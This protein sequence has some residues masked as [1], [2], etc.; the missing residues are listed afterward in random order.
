MSA[1]PRR[2]VLVCGVVPA[3]IVALL[4][5]Y[6]PAFLERLEYASY[7]AL[8]RAARTHP[9]GGDVVIVDVDERSLS[10]VGQWPWRRNLV[11]N[12]VSRIRDLSASAIALDIVFAESDRYAGSGAATD[13]AMAD[14]LRPGKVVLGYALTFDNTSKPS[15]A[16]M[17]HPLGLVLVRRGDERAPDPF[18][19]ATGVVCS[20]PVLT[21]AAGASGFFNAAPDPDGLLR[22]VPL[23]AAFDG[24]VYPSL[25]LAAVIAA[26]NIHDVSLRVGNVNSATLWFGSQSVPLDGKSNMRLRYRGPRRTF[27]YV[28][29]TDVLSG[30]VTADA[31]KDKIVFVGTTALGTREVVSTPIDT[32]F[33]GVEVQAT[34]ADNLLQQDYIR[35]PE[36]GSAIETLGVLIVGIIVSLLV[37]R[38]GLAWGGA[39]IAAYL[40][41]IW[42]GAGG[43]MSGISVFFS[44]LYPTLGLIASLGAI[45]GGRFAL[46]RNRADKAGHDKIISQRLMVQ[47]LLSLTEVRD[48]ETGRHS[49]RTQ[50]Y[51]R[52]LATQLAR[53]PDF[54]EYLTPERIELLAS[55]A[56]LH[57][58]GKVGVP[59]RLLNKAGMLTAEE[60]I[61]M[62]KHP[63]HGRDV[64]VH[65]ERDA[66][67]SDD[68]ILAMA[69]EIVYTHH[70]KW[71][72][73]GYPQGLS[74]RA[75]PI[76]GRLIALVDVYDAV[77][78]RRAY[79]DPMSH[80]EAVT[81]IVAGKGT[82]FD[83]AVVDAFVQVSPTLRRFT[84]VSE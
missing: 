33:A 30:E 14:A 57:D 17:Q 1:Q 63:V 58:I 28:S 26:R 43:L 18:F 73:T 32:L 55:L 65:A 37:A 34:V 72:G 78:T 24:H 50:A 21:K 22:R 3:V 35:R 36:Y 81:F 80:D 46:E 74:G 47:T 44:P 8:L 53:H 64:I 66:G 60:T 45:A 12:L 4:S 38:F 19:Q 11:G 29:A 59:D 16:C 10:S 25:G 52:V 20:L 84:P 6:R 83:P 67:S 42:A 75:I 41:V 77:T 79:R 5:L 70:E 27:Q 48:I 71:D 62:R 69:K 49:R 15:S 9:P 31:F 2:V 40:L 23:L 7:D 68:T 39:T 76:V 56:P 61:E 13:E 82:H 54:S 51:A